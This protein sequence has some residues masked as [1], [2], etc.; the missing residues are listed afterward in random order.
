[1]SLANIAG[2]G[3]VSK[4]ECGRVF[5]RTLQTTPYA[6]LNSV[7]IAHATELMQEGGLTLTSIAMRVGFGSASHFS[8]AFSKTMGV[9]PR[10]YLRRLKKGAPGQSCTA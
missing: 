10:T 4:A 7:R 2:A 6:Y 9:S 1:M 8:H 3:G 5:R